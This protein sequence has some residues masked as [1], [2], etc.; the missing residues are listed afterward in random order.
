MLCSITQF[1]IHIIFQV[2]V[3]RSTELLVKLLLPYMILNA[4]PIL[5][6]TQQNP[7]DLFMLSNISL[8]NGKMPQSVFENTRVFSTRILCGGQC[9][10]K[11]N[12]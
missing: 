8:T 1:P 4:T 2:S 3:S 10:D 9:A 5:L 6:P 7:I 12:H 11:Y